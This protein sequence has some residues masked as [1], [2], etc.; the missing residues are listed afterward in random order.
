V[1]LFK[2]AFDAS[3]QSNAARSFYVHAE[4]IGENPKTAPCT[5]TGLGRPRPFAG[6]LDASSLPTIALE[7]SGLVAGWAETDPATRR[8]FAFTTTLDS[9][10]RRVTPTVTVTPEAKL[11]QQPALV[12]LDDGLALLYWDSSPEGAGV[13]VRKLDPS[14]SIAGAPTAVSPS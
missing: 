10:L 2:G 14:G 4:V 12:S 11:V 6:N 13:F 5:V 8:R 3:G 1:Q 9:V 7:P